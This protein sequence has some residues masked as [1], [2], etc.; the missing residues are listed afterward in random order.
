MILDRLTFGLVCLLALVINLEQFMLIFFGLNTS[1]ELYRM[2]AIVL[3]I[4]L[5]FV[6]NKMKWTWDKPDILIFLM[7]GWGFFITLF[8]YV[9]LDV[10]VI[11][12]IINYLLFLINFFMY[13]SLKNYAWNIRRISTIIVCYNLGLVANLVFNQIQGGVNE[14]SLEFVRASGFFSNPNSLALASLFGIAGC[15]FLF[16]VSNRKSVQLLSAFFFIVNFYILNQT[17]SRA[18]AILAGLLLVIIIV[19]YYYTK[20]RL[21][22]R[23]VLV[24]ALILIYVFSGSF[25]IGA[26][27]RQRSREERKVKEERDALTLAGLYAFEDSNYLG[28]G[29]GQFKVINNF[30]K[31]VL[32]YSPGIANER[33]QKNEGLVTHNSYTQAL[34]ETGFVGFILLVSFWALLLRRAYKYRFVNVHFFFLQISVISIGVIYAIGHVTFIAPTLWYNLSII[35]P[36][37]LYGYDRNK[38]V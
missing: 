17:S 31:Y 8:R 22:N 36:V 4:S 32:P 37:I 30:Y 27:E 21:V 19:W 9:F 28:L 14:T 34:A 12:T 5:F 15:F 26:L 18:G 11:P 35:F 38:Q 23:F 13:L 16:S 20:K 33:K 3:T 6:H 10:D 2:V 7:F 25:S 24:S 29:L 1:F